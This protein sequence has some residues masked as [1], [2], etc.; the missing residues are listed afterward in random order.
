MIRLLILSLLSTIVFANESEVLSDTKKDIIDLTQKQINETQ[1]VNKYDWLSDID[2]SVSIYMDED[3]DQSQDYSASFSQDI[4]R[5]GGIVSQ[6]EYAKELKKLDSLE[7]I[8]NTKTDI[9]ALYSLLIDIKID[10]ISLEQNKLNLKNSYI[11]IEHKKS[12]YKEGDIGISDLNEAM[13]TKNELRDAQKDLELSKQKN[14]TSLKEYTQRKYETINIPNISILSR[15]TFLQKSTSIKYASLDANVNKL[16]YKLKKSDYLPAISIDGEY[17]YREYGDADGYSTGA[18]Q[19]YNYGLSLSLPLSYTSS[20]EIQ[21]QE[22]NYLISKKELTDKINDNNIIYENTLQTL[23]SYKQKIQL[24]QEDIELYSELLTLNM[25][26]FKAGYKTIDDVDTLK[27]SKQ[28]RE[29]DI[30]TYKLN[31]NKELITLYFYTK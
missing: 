20:N 21:V 2:L 5:F 10:E 30:K 24:A 22:I 25:E 13:M 12:Q 28:I 6:V 16:N 26:E 7:L 27:N 18:G 1:Q 9:T 14:I 31:I 8:M 15:E 4:F 11:D 17:G 3:N 29:L 19:Y 23:E